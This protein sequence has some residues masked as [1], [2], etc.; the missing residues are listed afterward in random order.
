MRT[1]NAQTKPLLQKNNLTYRG[2]FRLPE[3]P[4]GGGYG[5]THGFDYATS[6]FA[7]CSAH[8][9]LF[10]NNHVYEQKTAEVSI[11]PLSTDINNLN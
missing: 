5:A 4:D 9:S 11:P 6:G 8:N 7:Y 10:I 1:A 3:V 2:A